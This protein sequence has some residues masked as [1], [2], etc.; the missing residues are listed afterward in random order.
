MRGERYT[1][2]Q[3]A[4]LLLGRYI[5]ILYEGDQR[6]FKFRIPKNGGVIIKSCTITYHC[7]QK[8]VN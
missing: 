6:T 3:Y 8:N 4:V 1:E 2:N 5:S 7:F